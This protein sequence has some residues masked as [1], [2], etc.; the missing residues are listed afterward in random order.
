MTEFTS[1]IK[2][3]PYKEDIIFS[4]LSDLNNLDKVKHKIPQDKIQD[5][6]FD[7]DSVSFSVSPIGKVRIHIVERNPNH[8]IKFEAEGLPV[9]AN[10]LVQLKPTGENTTE[11]QILVNAALNPFIKGMVSK[12]LQNG[13]DKMAELLTAIPYEEV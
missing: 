2:T 10:L 1:E 6:G 11:M 13:I 7:G 5:F 3:I 9:K 4:T 12:P 8:N